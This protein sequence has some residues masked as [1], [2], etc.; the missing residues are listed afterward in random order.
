MKKIIVIFLFLFCQNLFAAPINKI[1]FLGDSLTDNGNLYK[2]FFN[3]IPKSPPYFA[4]EFSNGHVWSD[5]I[6]QYYHDRNGVKA[7]NYAVGGTTVILRSPTQ[8]ALPYDLDEEINNF[9]FYNLLNKEKNKILFAVWMGANDYL[10]EV[11]QNPDSLTTD[12]VN[13]IISDLTLLIDK[14]GEHFLLLG[15]PD[16]SLTPY[17]TVH[18]MVERLRTV[19]QLHNE[20]L[21]AA[22]NN[23]KIQY[24]QV[25]ILFMDIGSMLTDIVNHPDQY[26]QQYHTHITNTTQ[27]CWSGG[28]TTKKHSLLETRVASS[29]ALS[30]TY[31]VGTLFEDGVKPCDHPEEFVFWDK[32]HPTTVTHQI[33]ADKVEQLIDASETIEK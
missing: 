12:V 7:E 18:N 29:T 10:D 4:G 33:L 21:V 9:L 22:L 27:S 3:I 30:E 13:K 17:A 31:H 2:A 6:S 8:G 28:Y 11:Q 15:M 14:G 5:F 1:V 23:L 16:L 32:L 26:N 20:K 25:D 19:S 24:P